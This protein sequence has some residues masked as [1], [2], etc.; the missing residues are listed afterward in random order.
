MQG[1]D[2]RSLPLPAGLS[3]P[4]REFCLELRRLVDVAGLTCRALEAATSSPAS[5]SGEPSFYSK[6]RWG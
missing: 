1:H 3:L 4:E 6:S 5:G 2:Q